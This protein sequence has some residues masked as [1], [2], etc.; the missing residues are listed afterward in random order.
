MTTNQLRTALR[1]RYGLGNYRI[2]P[3][4]DIH[5]R[6]KQKGHPS[7]VWVLFGRVGD[8]QTENSLS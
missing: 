8:P 7:V 2:T 1:A 4:G 3:T 6:Q 5:V